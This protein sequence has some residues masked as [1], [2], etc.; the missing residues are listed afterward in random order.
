[1]ALLTD[2]AVAI[3][4]GAGIAGK[5]QR[6]SGAEKVASVVKA[7]YR[8]TPAKRKLAGGS[9]SIHAAVV[10]GSPAMVAVVGD[11]VMGVVALGLRDGRVAEVIGTASPDR[12]ARFSQEWFQREPNTPVVESW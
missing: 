8:P 9:P 10:N 6:R 12:L 1:M 2:D 3:S 11:R 4:D 7:G 5:V